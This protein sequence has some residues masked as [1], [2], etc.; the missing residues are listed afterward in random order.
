[1]KHILV[2]D[3]DPQVRSMLVRF[4][5]SSGFEVSEAEDGGEALRIISSSEIDLIILDL[6][7][8]GKE[9]LETLMTLRKSGNT[10]KVIAV[11]GGA[12]SVSTDF[13]PV[14]QKLGADAI[15]RKPFRIETLLN[16][17][18]ELL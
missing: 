8:P 14:A 16:T 12:K 6:I 7:M 5:K 17:I 18:Q 9:G 15:L 11:S 13:L 4:L 3:D 1:M 10:S 2:V